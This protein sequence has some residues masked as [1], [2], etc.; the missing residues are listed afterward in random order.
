MT[1]VELSQP[2][3]RLITLR[4]S[5]VLLEYKFWPI[6]STHPPL[7]FPFLLVENKHEIIQFKTYVFSL[8][9]LSI[10]KPDNRSTPIQYIYI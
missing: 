6:L 1:T 5:N 8:R 9:V 7:S 3:E 4:F 10:K 2:I